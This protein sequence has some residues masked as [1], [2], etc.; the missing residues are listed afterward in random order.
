MNIKKEKIK[1]V[2]I[3]LLLFCALF[4]LFNLDFEILYT[5]VSPAQL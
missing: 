3:L 1:S 2:N 4:D 5:S